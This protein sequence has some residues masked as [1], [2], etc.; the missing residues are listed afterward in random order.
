[1]ERRAI[2]GHEGRGDTN[3]NVFP[4]SV[5]V[6]LTW[7]ER[8]EV[9]RRNAN[10]FYSMIQSSNSHVRRLIS[11]KSQHEKEMEEARDKFKTAMAAYWLNLNRSC[12]YS[13]LLPNK[14]HGTISPK[15]SGKTWICGASRLRRLETCT[16]SS[17]WESGE[18][19]RW[20]CL[21]MT[22]RTPPLPT[23]KT[24]RTQTFRSSLKS[25][26]GHDGSYPVS[27]SSHLS[28]HHID[29]LY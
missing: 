6:L 17:L 26:L 18:K 20:R 14:R 8:G 23:A 19:R 22:W 25:K 24:L 5:R 15:L 7:L 29:M 16:M 12:L 3:D 21:M 11:E 27:L 1:M 10:N 13:T 28:D 9:N 4:E 2:L